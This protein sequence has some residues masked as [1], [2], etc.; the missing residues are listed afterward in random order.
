MIKLAFIFLCIPA[1]VLAAP[2]LP[3]TPSPTPTPTTREPT[4]AENGLLVWESLKGAALA[5]S[6]S[7][8]VSK[9]AET[10]GIKTEDEPQGRP[11]TAA[12]G[13]NGLPESF[14]YEKSII[15]PGKFVFLA[16]PYEKQLLKGV[17]AAGSVLNVLQ[18][19]DPTI[20]LS[21]DEMFGLYNNQS[22]GATSP[23]MIGGMANLGFSAEWMRT[24]GAPPDA[25]I[26]R[27]QSS[28]VDNRPLI[29]CGENHAVTLVGFN[30]TAKTI[31]VW[32]QR[33]YGGN[34]VS[35][36]P[37]G[38]FEV[39]ESAFCGK[40]RD[41]IAISKANSKAN[42]D[43]AEKLRRFTGWNGEF[44]KHTLVNSDAR[45]E[46]LEKFANHAVPA[47]IKVA[48]RRNEIVII[49]VGD[50]GAI[51]IVPQV[52]ADRL[53]YTALPSG[54]QGKGRM[55]FVTKAVLDAGGTFYGASMTSSH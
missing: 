17:C 34:H 1:I 28:L 49:P 12:I 20:D 44:I 31:I 21:Q 26:A 10:V 54:I 39:S 43:T 15:V 42:K 3:G 47:L 30:K 50:K 14:R 45:K 52:V 41:V 19:M 51:S 48:M 18:Y 5:A 36:M 32:D 40:F 35:G 29:A 55:D 37:A 33:A 7:S 25:L 16:L 22:E 4:L 6:K 27:V 53:S 38:M 13:S 23:Q 8:V 2:N 24:R 9:V 46:T 11:S